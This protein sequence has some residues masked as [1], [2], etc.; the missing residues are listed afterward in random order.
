MRK[1]PANNGILLTATVVLAVV[2]ARPALSI[3]QNRLRC[4]FAHFDVCAH[5]LQTRSKRFNLLLLARNDRFQF[6][7]VVLFHDERF[8]LFEELI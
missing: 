3:V 7:E 5:F 4:G 1:V 8:V 2:G 6:L